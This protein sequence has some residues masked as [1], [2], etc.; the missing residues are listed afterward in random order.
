MGS[1]EGLQRLLATPGLGGQKLLLC[2][3]EFK[4]FVSKCKIEGSILLPCVNSLFESNEY[5]GNTKTSR[6]KLENAYLSILAASTVKTYENTWS[7]QFTD[8][9]FNN[10][11]F[12]VPGRGKRKYAVPLVIPKTDKDKLGRR[13]KEILEHV[14]RHGRL[15]MTDGARDL[16]Q[17]WYLNLPPSIHTKRIDTYAMRL[18]PLLA[19]NELKSEV[20]EEIVEKT[21][22]LCNWQVN[23]RR[24]HDPVDADNAVARMEEKIRRVVGAKGLLKEYELKKHVNANRTGLWIFNTALTN[25]RGGG[26]VA[27]NAKGQLHLLGKK[28]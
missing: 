19:I 24:L 9:G 6:I 21:L 28:R 7:N 17:A 25:L 1:A 27:G 12:L 26:E 3:D 8:I 23:V 18:M 14:R 4:Q 15:A 2:L 5:E 11:L 20:D 22:A 16:F 13:L 10:R